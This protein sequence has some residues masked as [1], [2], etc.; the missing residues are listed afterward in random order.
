M[1]VASTGILRV[2]EGKLGLADA[3]ED[4]WEPKYNIKN[5]DLLQEIA[6]LACHADMEERPRRSCH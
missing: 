6:A 3:L 1:S 4:M 5:I 2:E